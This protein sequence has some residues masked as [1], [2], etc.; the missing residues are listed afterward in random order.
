MADVPHHPCTFSTAELLSM[1][2]GERLGTGATRVS[3]AAIAGAC[4]R[5]N[6]HRRAV[7]AF[8]EPMLEGVSA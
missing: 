4:C 6:E 3:S 1:C 2:R 5:I 7:H 8:V